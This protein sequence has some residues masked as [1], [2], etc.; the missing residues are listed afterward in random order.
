MK[1]LLKRHLNS[2]LQIKLGQNLLA[3]SNVSL[4][5]GCRFLVIKLSKRLLGTERQNVKT[6]II[7]NKTDYYFVFCYFFVENTTCETREGRVKREVSKTV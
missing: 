1:G 2:Q 6:L 4:E 5:Q 7:I 3:E